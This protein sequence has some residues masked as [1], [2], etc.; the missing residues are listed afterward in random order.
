MGVSCTVFEIK[1]YV[2]RKR[3]FFIPP[4]VFNLLEPLEYIRISAPNINT[5]SP[6]SLSYQ[7]V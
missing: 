6:E 5:N 4:I 2:G 3:Q 1:G 7:A